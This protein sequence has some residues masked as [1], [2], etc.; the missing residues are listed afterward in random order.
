LERIDA[1]FL[2][3]TLYITSF[4][5]GKVPFIDWIMKTESENDGHG[6]ILIFTYGNN[7]MKK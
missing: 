6:M 5:I 3:N 4:L 7:L 2:A 1:S